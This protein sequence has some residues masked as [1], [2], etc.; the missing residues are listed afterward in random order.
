MLSDDYF[1]PK[2]AP[3]SAIR[4]LHAVLTVVDGKVIHDR[5]N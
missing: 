2:R 4:K 3:D 5:L 1:D